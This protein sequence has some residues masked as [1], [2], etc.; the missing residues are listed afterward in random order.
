M[1]LCPWSG[2]PW[3]PRPHKEH[4]GPDR[5]LLPCLMG[6]GLA[7]GVHTK[8][9]DGA[10]LP[11]AGQ[12]LSWGALRCSKAEQRNLRAGL[13]P[14]SLAHLYQRNSRDQESS[15]VQASSSPP[16]LGALG[17]RSLRERHHRTKSQ[18]GQGATWASHSPADGP[19]ASAVQVGP[20]R[21][22]EIRPLLECLAQTR[23][24]PTP[25]SPRWGFTLEGASLTRPHCPQREYMG[26]GDFP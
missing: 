10:P 19:A 16:T 2:Q 1:G 5:E 7:S 25:V 14:L 17:I 9:Q 23:R 3:A 15:V 26:T 22:K 8:V 21:K 13:S 12:P 4:L 20:L 18:P 24:C 11:G 6:H